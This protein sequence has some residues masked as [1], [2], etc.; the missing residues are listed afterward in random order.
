MF[1]LIVAVM[2]ITFFTM[3]IVVD[4]PDAEDNYITVKSE[5]RI[6]Q[7]LYLQAAAGRW[8]VVNPTASGVVS[9]PDLISN[10][11]RGGALNADVVSLIDAGQLYTYTLTAPNRSDIQTLGKRTNC[12]ELMGV[13]ISG[14]SYRPS[15]IAVT[16]SVGLIP[17]VIPS[18]SLI[19]IGR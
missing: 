18:N 9:A 8:F 7:F 17:S 10:M 2:G 4:L 5:A 19:I 12:S 16:T 15:C 14:N 13:T 11:D 6:N 3:N 1:P